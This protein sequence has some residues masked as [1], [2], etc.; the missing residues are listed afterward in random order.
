MV[1]ERLSSLATSL[2][3]VS[4]LG[5]TLAE[6]VDFN[7]HVKPI[8]ESTCVNCHGP[9]DADGDLRL[10]SREFALKGGDAGPALVPGKPEESILYT[11]TVLPEDDDDIMPPK[12]D[13]LAKSQT[14]ILKK[15]I[16][17][18]AAWPEEAKLTSVPRID[19]E[20]HIQPIFE[21]NCI[22]CHNPNNEGKS[23]YYMTTYKEAVTTGADPEE[24]PGLVPFAPEESGIFILMNLPEDDDELM[25]PTKNGG[26]LPKKDIDLVRMWML[27][28]MSCDERVAGRIFP[29]GSSI[30][31]TDIAAIRL[32]TTITCGR[33]W[34][35][36]TTMSRCSVS[37]AAWRGQLRPLPSGWGY[38]HRMPCRSPTP[39]P[40]KASTGPWRRWKNSTPSTAGTW[41]S[42]VIRSGKKTSI[43]RIDP[44]IPSRGA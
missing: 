15:W 11:Y 36:S 34:T 35:F 3:F 40:G 42:W 5:F 28:A 27:L 33:S 23:D 9:D 10:D 19:F 7:K 24:A 2:A 29:P 32:F 20:K 12:G 41:R 39:G 1:K 4:T 25:P 44:M 21:Q 17:E 8:L 16:E 22:T 38:R 31:W 18:G 26:P 6:S 43:S 37:K 13:P 30:T 14:D